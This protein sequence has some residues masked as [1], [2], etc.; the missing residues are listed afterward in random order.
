MFEGLPHPSGTACK[1]HMAVGMCAAVQYELYK[2]GACGVCVPCAQE[3]SVSVG[4]VAA[5]FARFL[6]ALSTRM[7]VAQL[8]ASGTLRCFAKACGAWCLGPVLHAG[9]VSGS[10]GMNLMT[11]PAS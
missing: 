6:P 10:L 3:M 2:R 9:Q 1:Y 8:C 4:P 5:Y 11:G 7:V